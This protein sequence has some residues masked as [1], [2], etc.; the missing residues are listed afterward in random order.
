[1]INHITVN[2][3]NL[4]EDIL[5][6]NLNLKFWKLMKFLCLTKMKNGMKVSNFAYLITKLHALTVSSLQHLST[7]TLSLQHLNQY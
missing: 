2:C 7:T 5:K 4:S 1:M 3:S 6:L